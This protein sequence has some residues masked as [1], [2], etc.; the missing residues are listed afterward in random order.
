MNDS[1]KISVIGAGN[2]GQALAA[3]LGMQGYDV[4]LYN[5]TSD[6]LK[7]IAQNGYI[8]LQGQLTGK[9][10]LKKVT[11]Q[12][13]EAVR[14]A[15]IIMIAT[16]ANAH[17]E[18]AMQ[19][20]PWL[21]EGQIVVLN[22]GRTGGVWE[23]RQSL[24]LQGFKWRIF[25]AEAQT[26]IYACRLVKQG[27]VHIIGIKDKVL[28]SAENSVDTSYVIGMLKPIFPCFTAAK[29]LLATGLEN[30][31]AIFHPCVVLFNAAAIERGNK[32]YFY[33]EMTPQ[34]SGFMQKVDQERIDVGKAYGLNLLSAEEWVSF[35]Y[36]NIEGRDL[37][38]KMKNNPA[39]F[40]ILAP[41]SIFSRQLMEDLP[42]GLLPISELGTLAGIET[43]LMQSV[44]TVC[45][46]LVGCDFR[47]AGRTLKNLG[48]DKHTFQSLIQSCN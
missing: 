22:P 35:A 1:L 39:Y 17:R 13:E 45:S 11:D 15:D 10:K 33:R 28:L 32:F 26:L 31:G 16:V 24:K 41:T 4:C 19:M 46:S 48:L 2:G 44:I 47:N 12:I 43:P 5:R 3:H 42:T 38:E 29:N 20:S 40:D 21:R 30:I 6:R 23:F 36:R 7:E 34:I 8:E 14:Y 25:L 37:C 18:L 27:V 9:G